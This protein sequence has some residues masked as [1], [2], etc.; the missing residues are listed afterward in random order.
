VKF[1]LYMSSYG[2]PIGDRAIWG[3]PVIVRKGAAP[4]TTSTPSSTPTATGT[5]ATSTATATPTNTGAAP[6]ATPTPTNTTGAPSATP[7]PTATTSANAYQNTKYAFR[8]ILPA[9]ASITSQSDN[10]GRVT[11]P[12]IVAGTNLLSKYIQIHVVE[13]ANPCV[14]PAVDNPTSS[15]NVTINNIQF[16]KQSGQGAAAG[17]RYDWTAYSTTRNNACISL[18][19]IL[20]SAVQGNYS[21]TPPAF[22]SAAES[23]VF[24]TVM[25]TFNWIS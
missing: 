22:D 5:A 10:V 3:N 14:S 13:G 9:G 23:A 17:N 19:F 21:P 15:E 8:F 6:S 11:L 2:S 4:P 12:I 20:H 1:I 24:S 16:N 7:T 18:A 25:S